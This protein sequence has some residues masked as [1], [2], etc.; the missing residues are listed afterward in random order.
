MKQRH[1]IMTNLLVMALACDQTR[2]FNMS[3]NGRGSNTTKLGYEKPHHTCTH[4]EPRDEK[5]GYQPNASWFVRRAME[6]WA[7][8][9]KAFAGIKEGDGTVLDNMLL[10]ANSDQ[11]FAKVHG[12]D[13]IP[14]F[15]A[16]R[17]GGK[18]KGGIHVAGANS[19]GARVG[20]TIQKVLG[21]DIDSWGTQS[22][23]TS[24]EIGEVLA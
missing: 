15:T 20:Y 23:T 6:S 9:V 22:N 7:H 8:Y 13:G 16:G 18:L 14:M 21:I 10:F 2:V 3:Y 1:E 11:S 4:E 24:K 17:A 19:P 12:M 5:L